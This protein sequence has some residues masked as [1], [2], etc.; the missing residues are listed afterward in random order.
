MSERP[1]ILP[2]LPVAFPFPSACQERKMSVQSPPGRPR[3]CLVSRE[4][5]VQRRVAGEARLQGRAQ[6]L[7]QPRPGPSGSTR[8]TRT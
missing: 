5:Q 2:S 3:I 8:S 1:P 6:P 7:T 4:G